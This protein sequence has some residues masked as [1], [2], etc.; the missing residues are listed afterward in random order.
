M[1][2]LLLILILTFSFHSLIKADD[3]SDFEIEGMS[4]GDSLLN[5]FSKSKINKN[6]FP[7]SF[8]SK[9]Y[10]KVI[11]DKMYDDINLILYDQIIFYIENGD[12]QFIIQSINAGKDYDNDL[13]NCIKE[14]DQIFNEMTSLFTNIKNQ[15]NSTYDHP[16]DKTGNSKVYQNIL[17]LNSG[18]T[19]KVACVDFSEKLETDEKRMDHL[20][21][22]I[23]TAKYSI[24]L[25]DE[26]YK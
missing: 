9:K 4:I 22:T 1:K 15:Q 3:I 16:Y 21:F 12:N 14:K 25:R 7:T 26:A 23:G 24:W 13:D 19:T 6:I 17:Y 5:K 11:F 18:A 8:V 2:R 10:V 20:R